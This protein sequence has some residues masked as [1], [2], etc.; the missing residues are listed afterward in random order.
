MAG[1]RRIDEVPA[2]QCA[3]IGAN[4]RALCHHRDGP[5]RNSAG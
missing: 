3:I 4:I 2:G 5:R 1:W